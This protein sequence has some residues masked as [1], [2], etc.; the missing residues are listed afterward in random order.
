MLGSCLG[1]RRAFFIMSWLACVLLITTSGSLSLSESLQVHSE[2]RHPSYACLQSA[3]LGSRVESMRL[4]VSIYLI[5]L[6][7]TN[8]E[9]ELQRSEIERLSRESP[10][11]FS[12]AM[13]VGLL[14]VVPHDSVTFDLLFNEAIVN[15]A[16]QIRKYLETCRFSDLA[17][18]QKALAYQLFAERA[19]PD[20]I[21]LACRDR[22]SSSIILLV[23][24]NIAIETLGDSARAYIESV[25]LHNRVP[26]IVSAPRN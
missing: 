3:T 7:P 5:T 8:N 2:A 4:A 25:T 10:N 12:S 9:Y 16:E 14:S 22:D 1:Q 18:H 23:N 17:D 13:L 26:S 6:S 24:Q 15:H 21:A 11:E 20:L 19:W